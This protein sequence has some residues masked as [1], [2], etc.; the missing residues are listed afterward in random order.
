MTIR[1]VNLSYKRTSGSLLNTPNDHVPRNEIVKYKTSINA[2][3]VKTGY[4]LFTDNMPEDWNDES[5][6]GINTEW[7]IAGQSTE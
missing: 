2:I 6:S 7:D 5:E 3:E 4:D 1:D